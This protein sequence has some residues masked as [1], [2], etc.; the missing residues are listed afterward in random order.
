MF[1]LSLTSVIAKSS[2]QLKM[3]QPKAAWKGTFRQSKTIFCFK[4]TLG[5]QVLHIKQTPI[6]YIDIYDA[7]VCED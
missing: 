3:N 1:F 6:D 4:N 7:T 5:L 2:T